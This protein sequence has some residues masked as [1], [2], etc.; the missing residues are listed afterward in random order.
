METQVEA[1]PKGHRETA[2][3]FAVM[4]PRKDD[5]PFVLVT[6][7]GPEN[8]LCIRLNKRAVRDVIRTLERMVVEL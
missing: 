3:E 5:T 8:A 6:V 1:R 4:Q 7:T 2:L